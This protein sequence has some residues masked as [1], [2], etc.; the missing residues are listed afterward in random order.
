MKAQ[1]QVTELPLIAILTNACKPTPPEGQPS[2]DRNEMGRKA[3]TYIIS[4]LEGNLSH[5]EPF[6]LPYSRPVNHALQPLEYA[7]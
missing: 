3:L 7:V 5:E 1:E 2:S 6:L 4:K